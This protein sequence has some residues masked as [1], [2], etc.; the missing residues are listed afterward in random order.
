VP[1]CAIRGLSG[2]GDMAGMEELFSRTSIMMEGR[3]CA[4]L[5]H[6]SHFLPPDAT[7]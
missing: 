7:S 4:F 3:M 1:Y 5:Y 2:S 6:K